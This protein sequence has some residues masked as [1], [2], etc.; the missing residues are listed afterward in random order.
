VR[1]SPD[2]HDDARV[3]LSSQAPRAA[4]RLDAISRE[5]PHRCR[6]AWWACALARVP[7]EK[8]DATRSVYERAGLADP[9]GSRELVRA[10]VEF[11][12]RYYARLAQLLDARQRRRLQHTVAVEHGERLERAV[13]YGRGVILV[14]PHLGDF[15]V[16]GSWLAQVAGHEVVATVGAVG[17]RTRQASFDA[18]RRACGLILRR[19]ATTSL[20]DLAG[21]LARGRI[22]LVMLDRR[23]RSASVEADLFGASAALSLAPYALARRTGAPIL[24]AATTTPAPERRAV[25]FGGLHLVGDPSSAS[26]GPRQT[27]QRLVAELERFIRRA[28]EQWHVPAVRSELPWLW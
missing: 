18:V 5:L 1:F 24:T 11:C 19:Q 9:A 28:P 26:S 15:E 13:A 22:V 8:F 25:R 4:S 2:A 12:W 3:A 27:T 14:C 17:Q 6:P 16:A 23:V 21:D 7:N 10:N 20:A